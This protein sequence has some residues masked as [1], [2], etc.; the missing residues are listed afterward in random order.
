MR[1]ALLGLAWAATLT[2]M[3]TGI[4]SVTTGA[5]QGSAPVDSAADPAACLPSLLPLPRATQARTLSHGVTLRVH[6]VRQPHASP[7]SPRQAYISVVHVKHGAAS[8]APVTAGVPLL[9]HPEEPMRQQ[10]TLAVVNGDYFE[11][12]RRGDAVPMGALVTD[13]VPRYMPEGY[14]DVIAIGSDGL[15]RKTKVRAT[16]L[17]STADSQLSI[18]AINDPLASEETT[19][20]YTSDWKRAVPS[21]RRAIVVKDGQVTKVTSTES[22]V[23]VPRGGIVIALRESS[24]AD[25]FRPSNVITVELGVSARDGQDVVSASGH[26]GAFLV[27]GRVTP[28]CSA[29]E[30]TLRPRTMLAWNEAGD[31]WVMAAS[32]R[33]PDPPGGVRIGGATKTQLAQIARALGATWA[34][35]MDGGGSTSL[36]ARV[37]GHPRR[38]DLPAES[39]ARPVPVLWAV[40]ATR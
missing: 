17:V 33:Q 12:L 18:G 38:I 29:Y 15:M 31:V 6:E 24:S 36:Y 9:L 20:A 26:G 23:R 39:W 10:D 32:T 34:V 8:V 40:S 35:T 4:N 5:A 19:V 3:A 27:E 30:N 14:H 7:A 22:S 11:P 13:G 37:A 25:T 21:G 16:G 1:K 28:A 2:L